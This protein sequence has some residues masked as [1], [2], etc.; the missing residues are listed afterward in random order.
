[1]GLSWADVAAVGAEY[2]GVAP[3]TS[4]GTPALKLRGKLLTRLR[5]E[6]A[7]LVLIDVPE[8]EKRMLIEAAPEIFHTTPH[9]DGYPSVLARL[10]ALDRPTLRSFLDQPYR[11]LAGARLLAEWARLPGRGERRID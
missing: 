9:Y 11:R 4:Y 10:S 5:P 7:S 3:G 6:D 1:M 2:P 8:D